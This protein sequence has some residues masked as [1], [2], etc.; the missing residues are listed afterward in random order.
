MPKLRVLA[1]SLVI[2][3][4]LAA[5][6]LPMA[7]LA[8]L[9]PTLYRCTVYEGGD[10]AG[11]GLTVKAYVGTAVTVRAQAD[12]SALGVAVLEVPIIAADIGKA[13]TFTVDGV[14]AT[15]TPDVD[16]SL[17]SQQ[18]RLDVGAFDPLDYDTD[19]DGELSKAETLAAINDYFDETITKDQVLQVVILYFS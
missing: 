18:V 15:E 19:Q 5:M 3:A 8:Q 17:A 1:V 6:V 9:P 13:I 14:I 12:T 2:I 7:V 11:A 10:L 4:V 16:V